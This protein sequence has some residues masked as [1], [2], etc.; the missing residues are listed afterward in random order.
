MAFLNPNK[1]VYNFINQFFFLNE[2]EEVRCHYIFCTITC[3][4]LCYISNQSLLSISAISR[5]DQILVPFK[6]FKT[7]NYYGGIKFSFGNKNRKEC[8]RT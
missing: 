6:R 1:Q 7:F 2:E 8:Q 5:T 4:V 3:E